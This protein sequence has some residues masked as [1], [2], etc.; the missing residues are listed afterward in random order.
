MWSGRL[1]GGYGLSGRSRRWRCPW[2]ASVVPPPLFPAVEPASSVSAESREHSQRPDSSSPPATR[3]R[4]VLL[5]HAQIEP[6]DTQP[7]A[8]A[9]EG[10][11][12]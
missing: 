10:P 3:K 2:G 9:P 4:V 1:A 7:T 12:A 6:P 11:Q 8:T 5:P